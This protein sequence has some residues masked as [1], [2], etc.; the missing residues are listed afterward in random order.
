MLIFKLIDASLYQEMN[1]S[2]IKELV[3]FYNQ[4]SIYRVYLDLIDSDGI[5]FGE[6]RTSR[7]R[8]RKTISQ[9][10]LVESLIPG[11]VFLLQPSG[12]YDKYILSLYSNQIV[13]DPAK[14]EY[15]LDGKINPPVV[16]GSSFVKSGCQ[17]SYFSA[18]NNQNL[19][20]VVTQSPKISF[21]AVSTRVETQSSYPHY[22]PVSEEPAG[23]RTSLVKFSSCQP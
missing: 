6:Y 20:K 1:E 9:G 22:T 5:T 8:M 19:Q 3:D 21:D 18:P 11:E 15:R 12:S 10:I 2:L 23:R 16:E 13:F 17:P 14:Q 7:I 4:L